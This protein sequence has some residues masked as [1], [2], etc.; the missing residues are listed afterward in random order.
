MLGT[1]CWRDARAGCSGGCSAS[2]GGVTA[3]P[4]KR[5]P[6]AGRGARQEGMLAAQLRAGDVGDASAL[7]QGEGAIWRREEER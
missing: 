2:L 6:I 3:S 5:P 7:G 4:G 1:R